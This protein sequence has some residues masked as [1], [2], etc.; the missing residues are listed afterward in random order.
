M[1]RKAFEKRKAR[2]KVLLDIDDFYILCELSPEE[3]VMGLEL[4]ELK[5]HMNMSHSALLV[6]LKRL[7]GLNLIGVMKSPEKYK[8]KIV[9]ITKNGKRIK[10]ELIESVRLKQEGKTKIETRRK[11]MFG[12]KSEDIL[13]G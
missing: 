9:F 1:K 4:E 13:L 10:E 7:Q 11:T 12:E 3:K 8:F 2:S 5:K 6:H